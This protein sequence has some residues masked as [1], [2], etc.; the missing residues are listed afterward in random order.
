M[1]VTEASKKYRATDKGKRT[2][3]NYHLNKRYGISIET[4]D[5]MYESQEGRCSICNEFFPVLHV[6][7]NHETETVRS[8]LCGP[9]NRGLGLFKEDQIILKRAS[10]YLERHNA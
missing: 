2:Y 10:K 3:K 6:D 4:Y 5:E 7:H 1:T 9:C 8:L